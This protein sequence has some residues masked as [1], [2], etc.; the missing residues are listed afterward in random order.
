[1]LRTLK[2]MDKQ[3]KNLN[4][5]G[6]GV[7]IGSYFGIF[8]KVVAR[9]S[10]SGLKGEPRRGLATVAEGGVRAAVTKGG[11]RPEGVAK[12]SAFEERVS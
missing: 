12:R 8:P 5:A 10:G 4:R 1:M 6:A 3:I 2:T 7:G 9:N 11:K